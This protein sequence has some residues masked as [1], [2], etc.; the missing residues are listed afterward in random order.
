MPEVSFAVVQSQELGRCIKD[1]AEG[2]QEK[3]NQVKGQAKAL[4]AF[5]YFNLASFYQFSYLK[6]K[7]ALT[8]P[9]YTEPTTTSSVGKKKASL[10]EIFVD[11][12]S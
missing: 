3:K 12:C 1:A 9:I 4:R 6:D 5:C 7:N 10:E 8:A 2:S 11:L